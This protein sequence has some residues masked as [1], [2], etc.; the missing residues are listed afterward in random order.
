MR[1]RSGRRAAVLRAPVLRTSALRPT[2]VLPAIGLVFVLLLAACAP[3]PDP[4]WRPE[5]WV[6]E[7]GVS[8][9]PAQESG[10]EQDPA[11][12][13]E[14]T[15]TETPAPAPE[16]QASVPTEVED[17]VI[18]MRIR[19]DDMPM[20]ARW[21][22]VPGETELNERIDG[23][24]RD[25]VTGPGGY[26]PQVHR[27]SA[28]LDE[29]GCVPG[30]VEWPA[31]QV[32]EDAAT[33][34]RGGSGIAVTCEIAGAFGSYIGVTIRVVRG[35]PE[36]VIDDQRT[37]LY[38]DLAGDQLIDSTQRW[39]A[40]AG[41]ELWMRTVELLRREAGA[42][43]RAEIEPPSAEQ[44]EIAT[45]GLDQAWLGEG[46]ALRVDI[47]PGIA[48]PELAD[49]GI[50]PTEEPVRVEV[51]AD[52]VETWSANSFADLEAATAEPFMGV[53]EW[54]LDDVVADCALVPCVALTYDDG[55]SVYTPD[56]LETLHEQRAPATF[57]MTG[58]SVRQN[59]EIV[60]RVFAEGHEIGSHTM[61]HPDLTRVK[62]AR[63]EKQVHSAARLIEQRTGQQVTSFRPPYGAINARAMRKIDLP[64]V[65]WSL[66]TNDWKRPGKKALVKRAATEASPGDIVLFHDTHDES[67]EAAGAVIVELKKRGFV[68]VTVTELFGGTIPD[69]L[70]YSATNAG[71]KP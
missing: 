4:D 17:A 40:D 48:A 62:P 43:S 55:P 36:S 6:V 45:A 9:V 33:G 8:L 20:Q 50:A 32:L 29:R 24:V 11:E 47:G 64:A 59:P 5:P 42:L 65:L 57:F 60:D 70:N 21:I 15:P 1:Q 58:T 28:G 27:A 22:H 41:R 69:G 68:P 54:S 44:E 34:P 18:G 38:T 14:D 71:K 10:G 35:A 56:L 51:A 7:N 49:L 25:A 39:N 23:I 53:P 52:V 2:A 61:T 19:N 30:S 26:E 3:A 37:T 13:G 63:A 67:V 12:D 46:G 16:S 31:G 66:D